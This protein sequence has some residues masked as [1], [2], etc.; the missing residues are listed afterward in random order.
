MSFLAIPLS[1]FQ[2]LRFDVVLGILLICILIFILISTPFYFYTLNL[3]RQLENKKTENFYLKSLLETAPEARCWWGSGED[4]LLQTTQ[5]FI[6]LLGLNEHNPVHLVDITNQFISNHALQLDKAIQR[7]KNT[8]QSFHLECQLHDQANFLHIHGCHYMENEHNLFVLSICDVTDINEEKRRYLQMLSH[9]TAERNRLQIM[10]D[11]VPIALWYR[12]EDNQIDYCNMVYARV[13]ESTPDEIVQRGQELIDRYRSTSAY[14]LAIKAKTT[15]SLQKH[16]AHM[17]IDGS[18]RLIELTEV[19]CLDNQ[20]TIGYALDLTEIEESALE[21]NKH[22]N[23]H[24]DVL[25]YLSTPIAIY[26]P[27]TKLAFFNTAF[28]KLFQ[29]DEAFLH[30]KPLFVDVLQD[31]RERRKL[32]EYSDYKSFRREQLQL[33]NT[34]IHPMEELIHQPDGHTL[35]VMAAPH[36]LGGLFFLY[37]D[38]SDKLALERRYN[39]LIA[40]QKETLDHLFEGIIVFGSDNRLR[41]S[42]PAAAHLW[43]LQITDLLPGRHAKELLDQVQHLFTGYADWEEFCTGLLRIM[44]SRQIH[45]GFIHR[46]D[47]IFLQYSYVPL[48]DGSHLLSFVDVSDRWRVERALQER[49]DALE[50]ADRLKS[51]FLSHVSYEL[52]APLNTIIGFIEILSNQYFGKLTERQLDYCKGITDSSQRLLSLIN[53]ILDLAS[54]EAGHLNLKLQQV[55]L[56]GMLSSLIGLIYNRSHDQG[57][58]ITKR[59][60]ANIKTFVADERRLKQALFNLLTNAMKFTPA[61]GTIQLRAFVDHDLL[62]FSIS[63]NGIG[64]SPQDCERLFKL[65]ETGSNKNLKQNGVGLGLPLVKSLVELHGGT[66]EIDSAVGKGTTIIIGIPLK[67]SL[68]TT[69]PLSLQQKLVAQDENM[70]HS[71]CTQ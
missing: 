44:T 53:D 49:N 17:I 61:G 35:R 19:P 57:L 6:H 24:Q 4:G 51:D 48:P 58:E 47:Q 67:N 42:N 31:L 11:A 14:Q 59:N 25:H 39:T 36:P 33:F 64:M 50:R 21:L 66:I 70:N 27:D 41:L 69:E 1:D 13:L 37:E 20:F 63:D 52:R 38:V 10:V 23:A 28:V 5:G 45:T 71:I 12:N 40:V 29:F 16:R 9:V 18:R 55:D 65:F 43:G 46:Q 8:L 22:I 60:E 15:G 3:Q 32:P 54:I 34:L 56:D 68:S 62:C 2:T 7:L 26:T 30:K